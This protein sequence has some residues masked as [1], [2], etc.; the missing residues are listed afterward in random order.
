MEREGFSGERTHGLVVLKAGDDVAQRE[1]VELHIAAGPAG[2][3]PAQLGEVVV[4]GHLADAVGVPV[5]VEHRR[6]GR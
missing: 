4:G 3:G 6:V 1:L 5:G 2:A